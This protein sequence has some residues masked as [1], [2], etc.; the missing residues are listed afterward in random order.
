MV[1]T[2]VKHDY[3]ILHK[4]IIWELELS[5]QIIWTVFNCMVLF[6]VLTAS[7]PHPLTVHCMNRS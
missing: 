2:A 4:A 3:Y 1:T 6:R 7:S 5:A